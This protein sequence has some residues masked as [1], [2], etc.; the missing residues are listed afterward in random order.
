LSY[1]F[2]SIS[3]LKD[4][5]LALL[6]QLPPSVDIVEGLDAL[7]DILPY[8]DGHFRY[9]VVVRH[10]S[11]FHDLAYNF[12]ARNNMCLVRSPCAD[13][14]TSP[15][16]TSDSLATGVVKKRIFGVFRFIE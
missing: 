15:I 12:F 3:E 11:W 16:I 13:I 14:H 8:L 7:R 1:F 4:K 10:R 2:D 9:A 5:L 6:I